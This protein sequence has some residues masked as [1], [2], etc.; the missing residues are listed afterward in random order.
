MSEELAEYVELFS[1]F[2]DD[3]APAPEIE[4]KVKGS[5]TEFRQKYLADKKY[6]VIEVKPDF[7]YLHCK[8]KYLLP[9]LDLE[10]VVHLEKVPG[11][12]EPM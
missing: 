11:I 1:K 12:Y 8:P 3:A 4:I 5:S 6:I 10:E 9:L 2:S 7:I